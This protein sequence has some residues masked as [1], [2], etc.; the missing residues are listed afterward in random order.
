MPVLLLLILISSFALGLVVISWY[1]GNWERILNGVDSYGNLCGTNGTAD[2]VKRPFVLFFNESMPLTYKMCVA[3]CPDPTKTPVTCMIGTLQSSVSS[4]LQLQIYNGSCIYNI[5]KEIIFNHCIPIRNVSS[6]ASAS[7]SLELISG[8]TRASW[9]KVISN[10]DILLVTSG[11]VIL[12]SFIWYILLNIIGQVMIYISVTLVLLVS[13]SACGV[14]IWFYIFNEQLT[15]ILEVSG[16]VIPD[17]LKNYYKISFLAG[18]IIMGIL[19][20]GLAYSIVKYRLKIKIIIEGLNETNLYYEFK[21]RALREIPSALVY[22]FFNSLTI[23]LLT[24]IEIVVWV[25]LESGGSSSTQITQVYLSQSIISVTANVYTFGTYLTPYSI[26]IRVITMIWYA[27]TVGWLM[28]LSQSIVA[29][30]TTQWYFRPLKNV[31]SIFKARKRC[32]DPS[33]ISFLDCLEAIWVQ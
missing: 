22:T 14:C 28:G 33:E 5:P 3:E 9:L 30:A 7:L 32:V 13:S 2:Y 8:K 24:A 29:G 27:W 16:Y 20:L 23:L 25:S 31:N 6:T 18:V 10:L 26:H 4:T 19:T 12:A 17:S 11:S 1:N 15:K 21:Y